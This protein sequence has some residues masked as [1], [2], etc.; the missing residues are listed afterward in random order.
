MVGDV[1]LDVAE[2]LCLGPALAEGRE[3]ASVKV[4]DPRRFQRVLNGPGKEGP[5][6]E[7]RPWLLVWLGEEDCHVISTTGT[8]RGF[9]YINSGQA[10]VTGRLV[11]DLITGELVEQQFLS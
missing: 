4:K 3:D 1:V 10:K 7:G 9:Q 6:S 2:E 8:D 5:V 11:L